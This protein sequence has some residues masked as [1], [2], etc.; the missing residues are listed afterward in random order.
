MIGRRLKQVNII[1][2]M[3]IP[4][5]GQG[6]GVVNGFASNLFDAEVS[7]KR[8]G[9]ARTGSNPVLVDSFVNTS[10]IDLS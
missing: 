7:G 10:E 4:T 1:F 3:T 9:S 8:M 6:A 2:V 5:V